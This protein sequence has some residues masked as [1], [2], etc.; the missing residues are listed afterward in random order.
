MN[1]PPSSTNRT[2]R[3]SGVGVSRPG[4]PRAPIPLRKTCGKGKLSLNTAMPFEYFTALSR[5]PW[6]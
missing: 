2:R 6:L 5:D 3:R 1:R 4:T